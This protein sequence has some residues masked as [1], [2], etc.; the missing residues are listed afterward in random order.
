MPHKDQMAGGLADKKKPEDFDPE[1]LAAGTKIEH[2]HAESSEIAQ[3][4]AMDHLTEDK[5]Y[6]IKLKSIEKYVQEQDELLI[7]AVP[8]LMDRINKH[9]VTIKKAAKKQAAEAALAGPK[10]PTA[11]PLKA[12]PT[13]PAAPKTGGSEPKQSKAA[14]AAPVPGVNDKMSPKTTDKPKESGGQPKEKKPTTLMGKSKLDKDDLKKFMS[15]EEHNK[16]IKLAVAV[17]KNLQKRPELKPTVISPQVA[18][19]PIAQ[20]IPA[21]MAAAP[22]AVMPAGPSA[23]RLAAQALIG[24]KVNKEDFHHAHLKG[25][26]KTMAKSEE[27]LAKGAS[28]PKMGRPRNS[29]KHTEEAL[30][31]GD[32]AARAGKRAAGSKNPM[33]HAIAAAEYRAAGAAHQKA[34]ESHKK[35]PKSHYSWHDTEAESYNRRAEVH[36]KNHDKLDKDPEVTVDDPSIKYKME[37][38][39]KSGPMAAVP[40]AVMPAG[41]SAKKLAAEALIGTKVNKEDFHHAHLKGHL[42]TM[43]KS[44]D[45]LIKADKKYPLAHKYDADADVTGNHTNETKHW[46]YQEGEVAHKI[47]QHILQ[48]PVDSK[49][50]HMHNVARKAHKKAAIGAPTKKMHDYHRKRE[51]HY[52][53]RAKEQEDTPRDPSIKDKM[54]NLAKSGPNEKTVKFGKRKLKSM[55]A[56][57]KVAAAK[58]SAELAPIADKEPKTSGSNEITRKIPFVSRMK[59]SME[60]LMK[61]EDK[62]PKPKAKKKAEPKKDD[63]E[64]A[65]AKKKA[66]TKKAKAEPQA[67]PA[68]SDPHKDIMQVLHSKAVLPT[69]SLQKPPAAPTVLPT[70]SLQPPPA[71]PTAA[72][73]QP[74]RPPLVPMRQAAPAAPTTLPTKSLQGYPAPPPQKMPATMPISNP[75]SFGHPYPVAREIKAPSEVLPMGHPGQR[76][77][78]MAAINA[79]VA[80]NKDAFMSSKDPGHGLPMPFKGTGNPRANSER[81]DSPSE[82]ARN[83]DKHIFAHPA[84][85]WKAKGHRVSG[86]S[87]LQIKGTGN[88]RALAAPSSAKPNVSHGIGESIA[89]TQATPAPTPVNTSNPKIG[90]KYATKQQGENKKFDIHK[91]MLGMMPGSGVVSRVAGAAK[92]AFSPD[93]E[94]KNSLVEKNDLIKKEESTGKDKPKDIVAHLR[95]SGAKNKDLLKPENYPEH[96]QD[97][98]PREESKDLGKGLAETATKVGQAVGL[99]AKRPGVGKKSFATAKTKEK[100]GKINVHID[101]KTIHTDK[102]RPKL[103]D[104][105]TE[106]TDKKT[107]ET[108][109]SIVRSR[110]LPRLP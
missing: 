91:F 85:N 101:T 60:D 8:T 11:Q 10:P 61:A 84:A 20:P 86:E 14:S 108:Q 57:T 75:N 102:H 68:T 23:K 92:R 110:P 58:G 34:H 35:D 82:I 105:K 56:R 46:R 43:A 96:L 106:N 99:I 80:P 76:A 3:E 21:P 33:D 37:D 100:D 15:H 98:I 62:K 109:S 39:K 63:K 41:P 4:I 19:M 52:A 50:P 103:K 54:K 83:K 97:K 22:Q 27:E 93:K 6:Y 55:F 51:K 81:F 87:H 13:A 32:R 104:F 25:H 73:A 9:P 28:G 45:E 36:Q 29:V 47:E 18:P 48:D 26:L 79:T 67:A 89:P 5:D 40:Q 107:S 70:K 78:D 2:E 30:H 1:Q 88:P 95:V 16:K 69:K 90:P 38:I 17:L 72:P 74:A 59:K 66:P 77:Q 44:E 42:K 64:K 24:T 53:D 7:K 94:L 31:A 71:A 49:N 12:N 65:P